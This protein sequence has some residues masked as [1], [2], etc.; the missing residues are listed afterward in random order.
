MFDALSISS[1]MGYVFDFY[2]F[3]DL[4]AFVA[5]FTVSNESYRTNV[6]YL[7][8]KLQNNETAKM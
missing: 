3:I 4:E 2:E 8:A 1:E 6:K 7:W 5:Q